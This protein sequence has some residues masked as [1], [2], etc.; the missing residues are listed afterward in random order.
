MEG[1]RRGGKRD[2]KSIE[3]S[4]VHVPTPHKEFNH[5]VMQADTKEK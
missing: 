4:Y 2:E 3:M 5:Y 1:R